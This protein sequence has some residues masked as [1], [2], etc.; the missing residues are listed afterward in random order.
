MAFHE[1]SLTVNLDRINVNKIQ[2]E[3]NKR[4]K[5][6]LIKNQHFLKYYQSNLIE[7]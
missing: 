2:K 7:A 3:A 4:S 6:S 5:N 1:R